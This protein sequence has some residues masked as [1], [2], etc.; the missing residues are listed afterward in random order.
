MSERKEGEREVVP[1]PSSC[2]VMESADPLNR[3]NNIPLPLADMTRE[4]NSIESIYI[5]QRWVYCHPLI[6][7][8]YVYS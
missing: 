7:I 3:Q 8:T 6:N 2:R 5:I 1:S 4:Q